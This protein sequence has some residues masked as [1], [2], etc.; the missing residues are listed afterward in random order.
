MDLEEEYTGDVTLTTRCVEGGTAFVVATVCSSLLKEALEGT[1]VSLFTGDMQRIRVRLD[2]VHD[3][4]SR[5][6]L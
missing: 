5:K 4:C 6:T 1:D 3:D 2:V